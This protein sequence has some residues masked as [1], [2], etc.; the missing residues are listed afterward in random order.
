MFEDQLSKL[1]AEP[2]RPPGLLPGLRFRAVLSGGAL[3]FPL[4][5]AAMFVAMPLLI[6]SADSNT[7]LALG[8]TQRVDGRVVS[9]TNSAGCQAKA[10]KIVYGFADT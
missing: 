5:M 8:R 1:P 7:R 3:V 4:A 10:R 9:A 6:L 2:P